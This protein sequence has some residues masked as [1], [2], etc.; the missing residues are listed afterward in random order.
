M[1]SIALAAVL[2]ATPKLAVMPIAAGEGVPA[3]TTAA[4]TDALAAEVRRRSGAEVITRKELETVLS[5]EAQKEM[6]GCQSDAC[7]AEIGGAL[8]V[9]RLVA[10]DLARLGESWLFHLKLVDTGKVKVV[11][12]ADRRIRG[13][14]IDDVLD[15]LP[16][17][18]GELFGAAPAAAPTP[19]PAAAP[20]P[21]PAVT[22]APAPAPPPWAEEPF[23]A[24]EGPRERR[25]VFT[26]GAGHFVTVVPA[27]LSS[28][29]LFAGDAKKLFRARAVGGGTDGRGGWSV[30]FWDPRFS[31]GWQRSIEGEAGDIHLQC[32]DRKVTLRRVPPLEARAQLRGVKVFQPRWRRIP[33]GLARDDD[34]NY[35]LLEGARSADGDPKDADYRLW[36]GP[37]K[38]MVPLELVDVARDGGGYLAISTG[39]KLSLKYDPVGGMKAEWITSAGSRA[40]TWLAP[41]DH[42]ALLYG[43]LSV[44]AGQPLGT[45]CDPFVSR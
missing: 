4:I 37:K 19:G 3:T 35:Y 43:E 26:D 20:L 9:E 30:T 32:G 18:V 44:W 34:G 25:A 38:K 23:V 17:M 14:T 39:G 7:I 11:A 22:A 8:G 6:L 41:E 2:A 28:H 5:L 16:P 36:V 21:A 33:H 15:A 29:P 10:G 27:T 12:Q 1:L 45:P 31:S 13:G 42:G 40:L 24:D